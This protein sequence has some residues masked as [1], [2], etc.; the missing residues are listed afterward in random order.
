MLTRNVLSSIFS[1]RRKFMSLRKI[2]MMTLHK[3]TMLSLAGCALAATTPCASAGV[4]SFH[5][6]NQGYAYYGGY[7]TLMYGQGAAVDPGNNVWNGFGKYVGGYGYPGGTAFYG[8]NNPDSAHG[9]VPSGLP[10]NPYAWYN[11][12]T[13]S[14]TNLFSPSNSG[15]SN[16]GNAKSDGTI[17]P[18]TLSL[19]YN[20]GDNGSTNGVTQGNA[21][22]IFSQAS[23]VSGTNLGTFTL[24]NVPAGTYNLFLYGAN[25]DGTRGAA[26]T[27]SSGT[28]YNGFTSTINP[29]S[30]PSGPLTSYI[31]GVDYVEFT[32]VTPDVNGNITGTWG[33]VFNPNSGLSGEG[34]FNGLQLQDAAAI[35]EPSTFVLIAIGTVCLTLLGLRGRRAKIA[36]LVS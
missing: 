24:G 22:K 4:I 23:L 20:G 10:G 31:L 26:F 9:T 7:N 12:T 3:I 8:G 36:D 17:S 6:A 11:G 28:P 33:A 1:A 25:Y 19:S 21:S 14:G 32:G 16:V 27:V 5:N 15:A 18:V 13:S 29:N 35:P 30:S 2:S 34:D